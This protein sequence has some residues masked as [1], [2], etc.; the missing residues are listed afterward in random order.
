M[1]RWHNLVAGLRCRCAWAG[2][3]GAGVRGAESQP[4]GQRA[5][6]AVNPGPSPDQSHLP[7]DA[8]G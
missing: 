8:L 3:R 6:P 2:V 4:D 5:R 1:L 7:S